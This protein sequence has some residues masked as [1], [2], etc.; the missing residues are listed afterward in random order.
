[1]LHDCVSFE[2]PFTI[3]RNM[4]PAPIICFCKL[5]YHTIAWL[6]STCGCHFG[7]ESAQLKLHFIIKMMPGSTDI[8]HIKILS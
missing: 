3:C 2:G 6:A 7:L 8:G 4:M 1:M 5:T